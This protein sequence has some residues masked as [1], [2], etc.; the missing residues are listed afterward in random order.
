[1]SYI[2]AFSQCLIGLWI[3][4]SIGC[5]DPDTV[6][7]LGFIEYPGVPFTASVASPVE[8]GEPVS[9]LVDTYGDA[10]T[11]VESTEV[12][13]DETEADITPFDRRSVGDC[14]VVLG[15]NKHEGSVRFETPGTKMLH[16]HGRSY[17]SN[18]EVVE[19]TRD[20]EL[21]VN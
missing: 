10:C 1:M 8:R 2:R 13:Q 16:I 12:V 19:V 9:V 7:E 14:S 20:L 21:I 15:R 5:S 4:S 18:T 3:A 11:T 6:V 17:V